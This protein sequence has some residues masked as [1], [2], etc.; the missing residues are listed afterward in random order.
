MLASSKREATMA[1]S[2]K[3]YEMVRCDI[4][5]WDNW[6]G[7]MTQKDDGI[8]CERCAKIPPYTDELYNAIVS[9][10]RL[11]RTYFA[12]NA[13]S[14]GICKNPCLKGHYYLTD[15]EPICYYCLKD[16]LY[17]E[18]E[19]YERQNEDPDECPYCYFNP[20]RCDDGSW[21]C[22]KCEGQWGCICAELKEEASISNH[23]RVCG[24]KL[25]HGECGVLECG[26]IDVCRDRC[27]TRDY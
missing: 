18:R 10:Q 23:R 15:T 20:C 2:H 12:A 26:C 22:E 16:E 7:Y 11:F 24:D 5:G 6:F 1:T 3:P 17:R 27:G 13:K 9:F 21:W 14:C 25:C 19:E 4:C 8:F